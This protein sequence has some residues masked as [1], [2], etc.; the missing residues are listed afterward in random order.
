MV[1]KTKGGLYPDKGGQCKNRAPLRYYERGYFQLI[2][3]LSAI[4]SMCPVSFGLVLRPI[5]GLSLQPK[6]EIV[7]VVN[8]N[9]ML[10]VGIGIQTTLTCTFF[11]LVGYSP[12]FVTP[13]GFLTGMTPPPPVSCSCCPTWSWVFY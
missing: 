2:D 6:G 11:Y 7:H 3:L 13:D 10:L 8:D 5:H 1:R 9:R 4:Y 12:V